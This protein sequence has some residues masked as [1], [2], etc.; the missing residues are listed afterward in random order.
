MQSCSCTKKLVALTR[1]V[2]HVNK[3][4][5]NPRRFATPLS[6]KPIL[7]TRLYK[8]GVK[9]SI[10]RIL[11]VCAYTIKTMSMI[12]VLICGLCL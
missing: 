12:R 5:P 6:K 11:S 3:T 7:D 1:K 9:K 8:I 10:E 4:F 2:G